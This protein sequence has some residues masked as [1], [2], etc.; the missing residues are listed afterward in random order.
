[1][2]NISLLRENASGQQV[3]RIRCRISRSEPEHSMCWE[4]PEGWS[5]KATERELLRV[6]AEFEHR[7]RAG[8]VKTRGQLAQAE[9]EERKAQEAI[10]TMEQFWDHVFFPTKGAYMAGNSI[11]DFKSVWRCYIAPAIGP[12][13]ISDIRPADLTALLLKMRQKYAWATCTKCYMLLNL[14]FKEAERLEMIDRNPMQKVEHPRKKKD[15]IKD[16]PEALTSDEMQALIRYLKTE[17]LKWQ[18][19]V[20]F[21]IFTSVRR[22]EACGLQWQDIDFANKTATIRRS[23]NYTVENGVYEGTPKT[24]RTRVIDLPDTVISLLRQHR[25]NNIL[26]KWVFTMEESADPMH[27][28]SPTRYFQKLAKE[29]KLPQLHPHALRHSFASLA[30]QNGAD[31]LSVSE[32]L[33]HADPSTTMR[34]YSH[35]SAKSRKAASAL[36]AQSLTEQNGEDEEAAK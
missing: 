32:I 11:T 5:D 27:P 31:I 8:E 23:L 10:L 16:E 18:T 3:Y 9:E 6:A 15:E 28:Q 36:F 12:R 13:Q 1:M 22:G 14:I 17:P 29:L 24:G 7:C 26:S 4:R 34:I 21:M 19:L 35:G 25:N 33:G 20:M 2:A 30:I